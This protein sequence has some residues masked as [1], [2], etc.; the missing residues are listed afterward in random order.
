MNPS[1]PTRP[2]TIAE[3][4]LI[5]PGAGTFRRKPRIPIHV[6]RRELRSRQ[7]ENRWR[8]RVTLGDAFRNRDN[9]LVA[10]RLLMAM[11]I[12]GSHCFWIARG[13]GNGDPLFHATR[14]WW[15]GSAGMT[16]GF[17]AVS[18]FFVLSGFLITHSFVRSRDLASF[19]AKRVAR[20]YPPFILAAIVAVLVVGPLAGQM[21][22]LE[23]LPGFVRDVALLQC[24][25][26]AGIFPN[27]PLPGA[28][29]GS[30]WS[31]KYEFVCYGLI[32]GLGL[33]GLL[34]RRRAIL[35]LLGVVAATYAFQLAGGFDRLGVSLHWSRPMTWAF[36][37]LDHWPRVLTYHLTGMAM[38]LYRDRLAHSGK[39]AIAAVVLMIGLGLIGRTP[40]LVALP[41]LAGYIGLYAGLSTI[42]RGFTKRFDKLD[43]SYGLY[44]Y[45]FPIQQLLTQH[46][47]GVAGNPL[48]MFALALPITIAVAM[49]S[50]RFVEGPMASWITARLATGRTDT[51]EPV[52]QPSVITYRRA[53]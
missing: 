26:I 51:A 12:L 29:N 11:V 16:F 33:L 8:R 9:N 18:L 25:T 45:A 52:K 14:A 39:L 47:G 28:L 34:E 38:Y 10:L 5:E 43:L 35:G 27:N 1:V 4:D 46:V 32:A 24:Y 3:P 7:R 36:G 53:A 2:E 30:L 48:L 13:N 6:V 17:V 44:L 21:L 41:L 15:G 20:I 49:L 22:S 23:R 19:A 37:E 42:S 50:A 40:L 31:I